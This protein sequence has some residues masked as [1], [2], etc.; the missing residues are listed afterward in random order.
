MIMLKNVMKKVIAEEE[1]KSWER[2]EEVF[3]DIG[4]RKRTKTEYGHREEWFWKSIPKQDREHAHGI[5]EDVAVRMG[6][7]V[8]RRTVVRQ[9]LK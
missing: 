1:R 2:T 3:F 7:R 4:V 8:Y 5:P 9:R 6:T